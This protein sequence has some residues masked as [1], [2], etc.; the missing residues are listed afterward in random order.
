MSQ[1]MSYQARLCETGLRA[2]DEASGP[3]KGKNARWNRPWRHPAKRNIEVPYRIAAAL[4]VMQMG[5]TDHSA[6]AKAVGLT[7][8]EVERIDKAQDASVRQLAVARIPPGE[9]F[10]LINPVRCPKCEA[11]VSIVPCVACRGS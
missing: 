9:S 6:I 2:E 8:D 3:L 5:V 7:L 4:A 1:M 10:K 11:E